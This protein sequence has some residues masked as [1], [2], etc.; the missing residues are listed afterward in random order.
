MS[1]AQLLY[2]RTLRDHIPNL[3]GLLQIRKEWIILAEDRE[4][5]LA[6]RHLQA[7]EYYNEYTRTLTHSK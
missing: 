4:R 1:P 6:N 5:A 2:G 3:P 7:I